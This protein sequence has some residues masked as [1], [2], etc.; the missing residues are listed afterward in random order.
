MTVWVAVDPLSFYFGAGDG[1]RAA[2][3]EGQSLGTQRGS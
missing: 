2:V 3:S 1:G